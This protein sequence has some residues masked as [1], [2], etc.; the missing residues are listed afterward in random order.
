MLEA[1]PAP[2]GSRPSGSDAKLRGPEPLFG[3]HAVHEFRDPATTSIEQVI[4]HVTVWKSH[5]SQVTASIIN[6]GSSSAVVRSSRDLP[7]GSFEAR[8]VELWPVP[9]R[10]NLKPNQFVI[11]LFDQVGNPLKLWRMDAEM[12]EDGFAKFDALLH[13]GQ[14]GPV[15]LRDPESAIAKPAALALALLGVLGLI[16]FVWE[17][18]PL[19]LRFGPSTGESSGLP[20][21]RR[22]QEFVRA[23]LLRGPYALLLIIGSIAAVVQGILV[24]HANVKLDWLEVTCSHRCRFQKMDCLPGGSFKLA[25]DPGH[26]TIDIWDPNRSSSWDQRSIE[27]AARQTVHFTCR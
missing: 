26:Y 27:L 5:F 25:L 8:D 6:V 20:V 14:S 3:Y 7:V 17:M 24:W 2:F 12:A 18:S 13:R 1:P 11:V 21:V 15:W 9:R 22:L 10:G 19:W 4:Y 23:R 16:G